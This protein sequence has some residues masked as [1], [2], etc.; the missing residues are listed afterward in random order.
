[1]FNRFSGSERN[2]EEE[3]RYSVSDVWMSSGYQREMWYVV[4]GNGVTGDLQH[5]I[6]T[7]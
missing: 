5:L 7:L 3:E 6:R 1:M 4:C 2:D